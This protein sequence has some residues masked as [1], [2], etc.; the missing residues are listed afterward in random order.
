MHFLLT[1]ICAANVWRS[2]PEQPCL[3]LNAGFTGMNEHERLHS[4]N[5]GERKV[6]GHWLQHPKHNK[7]H[8]LKYIL[9][10]YCFSYKCKNISLYIF[11]LNSF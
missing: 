1:E 7:R 5:T 6:R 3:C 10:I 2:H 9:L 11:L 4:N 8:Y